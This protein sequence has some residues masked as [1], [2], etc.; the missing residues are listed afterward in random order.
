M[1]FVKK[2]NTVKKRPSLSTWSLL[3]CIMYIITWKVFYHHCVWFHHDNVP[4][5]RNTTLTIIHANRI[6]ANPIAAF[7]RIVRQS[8]YHLPSAPDV[9]ILKPQYMHIHKATV[10][11]IHR[12]QLMAF[13]IVSSNPEPTFSSSVWIVLMSDTWHFPHHLLHSGFPSASM[14]LGI[15]D[16]HK[17]ISHN[18]IINFLLIL[19][20]RF[21]IFNSYIA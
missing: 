14:M 2:Y 13:L 10:A 20:I 19:Y 6:I 21:I 1:D 18:D 3:W 17:M 12:I 8:L 15:V 11:R 9:S 4:T 16:N 7:F 5:N